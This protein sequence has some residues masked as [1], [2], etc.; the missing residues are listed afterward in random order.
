MNS[1]I[2]EDSMNPSMKK[3]IE[4]STKPTKR[5]EIAY[6]AGRILAAKRAERE[7]KQ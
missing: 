4:I 2:M 5:E 7:A 6:L 1:Y 3:R